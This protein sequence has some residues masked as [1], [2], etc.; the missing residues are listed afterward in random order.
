[1]KSSRILKDPSKDQNF[2]EQLPIYV[3][4]GTFSD[5]SHDS[6]Q[7]VLPNCGMFVN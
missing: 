3:S 2:E 6:W 4:L 1:M 5:L 7:T